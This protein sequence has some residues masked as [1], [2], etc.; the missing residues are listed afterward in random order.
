MA[1]RSPLGQ[2]IHATLLT[3]GQDAAIE[4]APRRRP[5]GTLRPYQRRCPSGPRAQLPPPPPCAPCPFPSVARWTTRPPSS[6]RTANTPSSSPQNRCC[7]KW[8]GKKR[9]A[10]L[11]VPYGSLPRLVLIHIMTEAVRRKSR[12]VVLGSSFTDWMRRM[13]FRSI[14]YGPR[15][16]RHPHSPAIGPPARLRMDDPLGQRGCPGHQG[17]RG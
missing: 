4:L 13:G 1:M 12:H 2:Q 5:T 6:A 7:R 11:G 16:L 8:M 14:S 10:V 15:R 3:Q 17:V 9:L